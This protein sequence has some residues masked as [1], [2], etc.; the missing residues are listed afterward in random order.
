MLDAPLESLCFVFGD[1]RTYQSAGYAAKRSYGTDARQ[2]RNNRAGGKEWAN[3]RDCQQ[4]DTRQP[5]KRSTQDRPGRRSRGGTF[6]GF[7][8]LLMSQIF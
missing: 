1:P 4:T 3:A 6:R 2:S 5:S 8:V 7:G